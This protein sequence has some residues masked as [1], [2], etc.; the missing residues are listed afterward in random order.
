MAFLSNSNGFSNAQIDGWSAVQTQNFENVL[1]D[2][3]N[4]G[5]NRFEKKAIWTNILAHS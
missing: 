5:P 1:H 2:F 3:V 4:F